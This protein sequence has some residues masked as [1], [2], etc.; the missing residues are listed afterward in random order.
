MRESGFDSI[1]PN[2]AKST[3]GHGKS[4]SP[5]TSTDVLGPAVATAGALA[6]LVT[7]SGRIRPRRPL[8]FT[9]RR[10]MP[11]SRAS[12]RTEGPAYGMS[13]GT[14]GT[15]GAGAGSAPGAVA[16]AAAGRAAAA[17][18]TRLRMTVPW[19]TLSPTLTFN[20][21]IMPPSGA[22]T[23]IDALSD[24][25]VTNG[26]SG[27]IVSPALTI[28]SMIGTSLNSP[29]SGTRTSAMPAGAL[30]GVGGAETT[31][32]TGSAVGPAPSSSNARIGVPWLTLSPI[33]TASDFTM[34]VNGEG[35]SSEALSAVSYT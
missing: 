4:P 15:P 9:S 33:F 17:S 34:P 20:S 10:S 19:L 23:S 30:V 8:P 32:F 6:N 26:C 35:T 7:S 2:L 31:G 5:A 27:L 1:G 22:G 18:V 25:I 3:L 24:S 12:F 14:S 16:G 21:A 11:R 29:M 13:N 28:T